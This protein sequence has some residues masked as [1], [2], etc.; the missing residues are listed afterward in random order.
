MNFAE[1]VK[2]MK[3]D[4]V[5]SYEKYLQMKI[6][7]SRQ[8]DFQI[9]FSAITLAEEVFNGIGTVLMKNISTHFVVGGNIAK[10][11]KRSKSIGCSWETC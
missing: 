8:E 7:K 10:I 1:S 11:V 9:S 2:L 4:V 3:E 6:K 5:S